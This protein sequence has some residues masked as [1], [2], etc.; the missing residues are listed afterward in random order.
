[1]KGPL[2]E[3][4]KCANGEIELVDY[5]ETVPVQ[6]QEGK[7]EFLGLEISVD[8]RVLIPRSETELLV[9]VASDL[10]GRS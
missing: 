9:K 3:T 10:A 1:M 7:A 5:S 2:E 6:Y 4:V 8:P